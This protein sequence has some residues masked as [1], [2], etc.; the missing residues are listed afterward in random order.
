[1]PAKMECGRVWKWTLTLPSELPFWEL[2]T[3]WTP[4]SSG[5]DCR[6]QNTFPSGILYIIGKLLKLRC[7]KWV[8]W[9]IWTS[10]TQVM[11]KRKVKSQIGNLT[12]E[13]KPSRIDPISLH[14]GGV[15][16]AVGKLLTRDTTLIQVSSQLEV[17][18]QSYSPA[19]S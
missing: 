16:H 15:R 6:G 1:M 7:L 8:T 14:A 9:P 5:S 4:K 11:G 18:T 13:H 2:G 12:P 19:K 17:Y 3:R 10:K